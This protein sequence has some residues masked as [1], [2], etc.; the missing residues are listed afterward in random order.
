MPVTRSTTSRAAA[1]YHIRPRPAPTQSA[2]PRVRTT[3]TEEDKDAVADFRN[4]VGYE[5]RVRWAG[6]LARA[7]VR[8]LFSLGGF[9]N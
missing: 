1:P 7:P 5:G 9:S 8:P 4:E 2:T 3:V 6:M